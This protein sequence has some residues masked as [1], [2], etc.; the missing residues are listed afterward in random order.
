MQVGDVGKL[1]Q[2]SSDTD[3]ILS[4]ARGCETNGVIELLKTSDCDS[5]VAASIDLPTRCSGHADS[6]RGVSVNSLFG[7]LREPEVRVHA[8][9]SREKRRR[10]DKFNVT[11]EVL[12]QTVGS[13]AD[14][15]VSI[16][17]VPPNVVFLSSRLEFPIRAMRS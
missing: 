15:S 8:P 4:L 11:V 9:E 17:R 13:R 6:R 7:F 16:L 12:R 10:L 14:N 2:V 5:P 3:L 1:L